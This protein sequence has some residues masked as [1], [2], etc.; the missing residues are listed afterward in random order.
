MS[1]PRE[2]HPPIA[3]EVEEENEREKLERLWQRE[4]NEFKESSQELSDRQRAILE[5]GSGKEQWFSP[6]DL[7][8]NLK[9]CRGVS[10][11]ELITDFEALA[12]AGYGAVRVTD[13]TAQWHY[14]PPPM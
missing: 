14:F 9:A 7:Q 8:A 11:H 1:I 12:L 3:T 13:K 2:Y 10:A 5:Y 4:D 6:S